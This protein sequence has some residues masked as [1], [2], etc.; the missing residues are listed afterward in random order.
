MKLFMRYA[1]SFS[2]LVLLFGAAA[3]QRRITNANIDAVKAEYDR[4]ND[5]AGPGLSPKE[6]ESILG[7]P[8][9]TDTFKIPLE[10]QHKTLTGTRYYYQQDGKT[11]VL[12]FLEDRLVSAP[13]H[14]DE[15]ATA[16]IEQ[17]K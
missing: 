12:H 13:E 5:P 3:C 6:V 14:F 16:D 2:S 15:P 9:R 10:T 4:K 11:I 17:K 8:D 7:Q 1:A